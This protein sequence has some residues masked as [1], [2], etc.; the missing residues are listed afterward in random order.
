VAG[1]LALVQTFAD[2]SLSSRAAAAVNAIDTYPLTVEQRCELVALAVW[3]TDAV[4]PGPVSRA[5]R[6]PD[7]DLRPS[8]PKARAPAPAVVVERSSTP[9]QR[10]EA[11]AAFRAG[12]TITGLAEQYGQ[13]WAVVRKWIRGRG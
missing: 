5:P 2:L 1:M 13:P 12:A 7:I 8:R 6:V 3:P 4:L 9:Q 10:V 11:R